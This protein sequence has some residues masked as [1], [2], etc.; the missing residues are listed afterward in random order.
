MR[1]L[2]TLAAISIAACGQSDEGPDGASAIDTPPTHLGGCILINPGHD[3]PD[4]LFNVGDVVATNELAPF[5]K[6]LDVH[7]LTLAARDDISDDF[8]ALVAQTIDE[9]F[10]RDPSLDLVMQARVIENH[11]RYGALIPVP[12]GQDFS[13]MEENPEQWQ[14]LESQYSICDIIMQDVPGQVMEVVEH[15]LHYVTD[16]GLHYAY[17]DVWGI[18]DDSQ[19]AVAMRK[20]VDMGYYNISSYDD[21][22]NLEAR[23]RVILQEFA[24]WFI[25]TAWNLQEP[26]GP[27]EDEWVI[28]NRAELM[29]KLPDFFVAYQQTAE[30]VMMAP[31]LETLQTIGPTRAEE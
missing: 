28:R 18:S 12:L 13:F 25:S 19:L 10:P 1:N 31:G 22:D 15:I 29:E 17:P 24:Y 9:I 3:A 8:M 21:I 5:T 27:I 26:Y 6:R 30:R 7:G 23:E 14:A 20:A 16:I 4:N 2:F 11:Y